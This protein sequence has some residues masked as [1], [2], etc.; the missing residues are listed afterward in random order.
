MDLIWFAASALQR[1][2]RAPCDVVPR[3]RRVVHRRGVGVV[4]VAQHRERQHLFRD[5]DGATREADDVDTLRS[6]ALPPPLEEPH[7]CVVMLRVVRVFRGAL[8]V[9]A[10]DLNGPV[11][12]LALPVR[13]VADENGS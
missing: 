4:Y 1:R 10:L 11:V 12:D 5:A 6:F 9:L 3:E 13:T 7:E 8:I 2:R